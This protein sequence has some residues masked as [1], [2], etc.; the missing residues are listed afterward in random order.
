MYVNNTVTYYPADFLVAEP[1][2][3]SSLIPQISTR[4]DHELFYSPAFTSYL[5]LC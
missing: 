5:G 1:K 2:D 3:L 4:P